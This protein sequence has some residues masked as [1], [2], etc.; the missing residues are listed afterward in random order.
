MAEDPSNELE[1]MPVDAGL[2]FRTEMFLNNFI[3]GYWKPIVISLALVLAIILVYVYLFTLFMVTPLF[4]VP[5][6]TRGESAMLS[7]GTG[8]STVASAGHRVAAQRL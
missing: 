5:G 8:T 6:L 4:N 7:V 3:M 2:A 1:V